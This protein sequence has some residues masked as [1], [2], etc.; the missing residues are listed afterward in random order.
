[1]SQAVL[2]RKGIVG[3]HQAWVGGSQGAQWGTRSHPRRALNAIHALR[4]ILDAESTREDLEGRSDP[5][6]CDLQSNHCGGGL[7]GVV[8]G[9]FR[10]LL[11]SRTEGIRPRIGR[12]LDTGD[13]SRG[14]AV[15]HGTGE[16]GPWVPWYLRGALDPRG[17]CTQNPWALI[18]W[19]LR[20]GTRQRLVER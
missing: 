14:A 9:P 4:F 7:E 18:S 3:E 8:T 10:A 1:M 15:L 16:G 2:S 20:A 13:R 11:P 6:R 17:L 12:D 19:R 5:A